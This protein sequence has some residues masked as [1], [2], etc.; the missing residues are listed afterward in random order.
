VPIVQA[1]V[2]QG[3]D[4]GM[5]IKVQQAKLPKYWDQKDK[6]SITA[7]EFVKQVDKMMSA[8]HWSDKI[9]FD[10]FGLPLGGSANTWFDS[11]IT[12]KK[13]SRDREQWMIIRPFFKEEFATE[14]DN[15][16]ILDGLAHMAMRPTENI[17]D[18]FGHLNKVKNIILDAYKGY[19]LTPPEPIPDANGNITLA[20]HTA[21]NVA[22]VENVV[23]FYLLNQFLA[24]LPVDLRR[25]I[26]LQPMQTL[27]LDTAVRLATIELR[28]KDEARGNSRIQAVQQEEE[29]EGVATVIQ[30][31]H[32]KFFPQNQ[33]NRGQQN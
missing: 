16:Q 19:T 5:A 7:N 6:D 1:Q 25:V 26:N 14:S 13:I 22:L 27:D 32:K 2:I 15:K 11:Q 23:E 9:A 20:A 4:G 24:A 8:N 31:P 28:S 3:A 18:F 29:E 33:Q 12:F 17:R 10:N 30:N 21:H